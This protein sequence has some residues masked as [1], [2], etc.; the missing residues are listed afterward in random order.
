[1]NSFTSWIGGKKLLRKPIVACFPE[2]FER[3]IEVFGGAA[4]IL[5]HKP[6]TS[7]EVYNDLNNLLVNLFRH[8]KDSP[9]ELKNALRYTLNS[10]VDF[11]TTLK[12]FADESEMSDLDRAALY[13]QLLRFSYASTG[14]SYSCQPHSMWW[15][16]P[17]IEACN[18]RLQRTGVIV[19]NKSFERLI[20]HYDREGSFFYADPPYFGT[21]SYYAGVNFTKENHIILRDVLMDIDGKFLLSYNDCEYIREL[22][23]YPEITIVP[24]ARLNNIKQ[25]YDHGSEYNELFIAN[26]DVITLY[27]NHI[28]T[29]QQLMLV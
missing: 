23:D 14:T 27:E 13:Y 10:R 1:M 19:E 11:N 15:D 2:S 24:V 4:W 18:E 6:P 7:F 26:Y 16:F 29:P 3:Y 5:F 21:E 25:R 17:Q 28:E 12:L 20:P 8:V 22:Y 9:E